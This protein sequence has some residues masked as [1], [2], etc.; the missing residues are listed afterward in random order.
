[1]SQVSMIARFTS[2]CKCGKAIFKGAAIW[3][4]TVTKKATHQGSGCQVD[5]AFI[6][7]RAAEHAAIIPN[8]AKDLP[9]VGRV[10]IVENELVAIFCGKGVGNKIIVNTPGVL[11]D[12]WMVAEETNRIL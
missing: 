10:S 12:A 2:K 11:W 4:D 8:A 9:K 3:Y 6:A 7:R 1:M 5:Q